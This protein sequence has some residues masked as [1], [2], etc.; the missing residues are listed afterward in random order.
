[1][2]QLCELGGLISY[3]YFPE[4]KISFMSFISWNKLLK[5]FRCLKI[6][7]FELTLRLQIYSSLHFHFILGWNSYLQNIIFVD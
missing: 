6:S 4:K 7:L 2:P 1:M 5:E 3:Y